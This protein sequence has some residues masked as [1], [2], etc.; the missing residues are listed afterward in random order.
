MSDL[1]PFSDG[2]PVPDNAPGDRVFGEL[3]EAEKNRALAKDE[4]AKQIAALREAARGQYEE[5][6]LDPYLDGT[7]ER[8]KPSIGLRRQDA[9]TGSLQPLL[10][11][12]LE[13]SCIGQTESGKSWFAAACCAAE[14]F[15]GHHV[16][17]LHF[18]ESDP[19]DI[20]EKLRVCGA[21]TD[22]IRKLFHFVGADEAL[23][24]DRL[25]ATQP[26]LTVIDGVNEA[27]SLFG[28]KAR[29]EDGV[30]V[31]RRAV[32]KPFTVPYSANRRGAATLSLD[33]VVKDKEGGGRYALGSGHKINVVNGAVFLLENVQPFG[34][35][36]R[37]SS[38]VYVTK[39]RPGYL[40][41][42]GHAD[43]LPGKTWFGDMVIDA[44]FDA[45]PGLDGLH[46]WAP[47]PR[48]E[49]SEQTPDQRMQAQNEQ[50]DGHAFAVVEQII[51]S[52]GQANVNTVRAAMGCGKPKAIDAL[53]RL[54]N[55]L[56]PRL[57]EANGP[58]RSRIY[59]IR[60]QVVPEATPP[61]SEN[62]S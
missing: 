62:D 56:T 49:G 45:R 50:T 8:P 20:I 48:A 30:S 44:T 17:Y 42:L 10:Y 26:T 60:S 39:D 55:G 46:L 7:I 53:N 22:A 9:A 32:V 5:I 47:R 18:E 54:A 27:M 3:V 59:T 13:H 58:N 35:D 41:K 21:G 36:I 51:A 23:G 12:G 14:L 25:R 24:V 11:P 61:L 16:V 38:K 1:E 52:G 15:A 28:Q 37:G 57:D 4:A 31:F 29:E 40:R 34:R 2:T 33:H 19:L 6:D 43:R